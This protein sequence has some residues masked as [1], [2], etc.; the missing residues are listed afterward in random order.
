VRRAAPTG[1]AVVVVPAFGGLAILETSTLTSLETSRGGKPKTCGA[2]LLAVNATL[3]QVD[4][5]TGT[6]GAPTSQIAIGY[7]NVRITP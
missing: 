7:G 3:R 5:V 1:N 6:V 2:T 4:L